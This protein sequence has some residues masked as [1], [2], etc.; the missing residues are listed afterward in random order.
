MAGEAYTVPTD[1]IILRFTSVIRKKWKKLALDMQ[2][3]IVQPGEPVLLAINCR[4]IPHAAYG[5]ELPYIVKA[6]FPVGA[7][8]VA[9]DTRT[10]EIADRFHQYRP[11]VQKENSARV[12]TTALLDAQADSFCAVLHSSV[13]CANHPSSLGDDFLVLHNGAS[14]LRLPEHLFSW[15]RQFEFINNVLHD[16]P[17]RAGV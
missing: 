8:T 17:A 11:E 12:A 4:G 9:I 15:C 6:V 5:A 10:N 13:D 3:G 7:Y 1:K 16:I 14:S 2:K